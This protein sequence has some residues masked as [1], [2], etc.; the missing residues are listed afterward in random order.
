[1]N[2]KGTIE[3]RTERLVLRKFTQNDFEDVFQNYGSDPLVNRYISYAPCA[4]IESAK[5]FIGMH[6]DQYEKNPS[7]YGWALTVDNEVIGS[8]GL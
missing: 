3:I 7:F 4:E 8:I 6:L 2:H 1:M 5:G